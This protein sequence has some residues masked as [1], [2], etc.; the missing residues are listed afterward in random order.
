MGDCVLSSILDL[1]LVFRVCPVEVVVVETF[2]QHSCGTKPT[3]CGEVN[4]AS[5][6]LF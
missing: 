2:F 1:G 3:G 6:R 5:G 4:H